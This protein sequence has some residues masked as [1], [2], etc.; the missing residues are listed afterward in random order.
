[1]EKL[2]AAG[3]DKMS[4][5]IE[6]GAEMHHTP[7]AVAGYTQTELDLRRV[8]VGSTSDDIGCIAVNGPEPEQIN[9]F[10]DPNI[11]NAAMITLWSGKDAV[12]QK[13]AVCET[14]SPSYMADLDLLAQNLRRWRHCSIIGPGNAECW[15]LNRRFDELVEKY[16]SYLDD[17]SAPR[18]KPANVYMML[19]KRGHMHFDNSDAM[20]AAEAQM[21]KTRYVGH[22][23]P[24]SY[25]MRWA[26]NGSALAPHA[27]ARGGFQRPVAECLT[28]SIG[29]LAFESLRGRIARRHSSRQQPM[30]PSRTISASTKR[31]RRKHDTPIDDTDDGDRPPYPKLGPSGARE[32]GAAA[33]APVTMKR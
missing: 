7:R 11:E 23:Q 5:N 26:E 32:L 15:S 16:T 17:R 24:Q 31:K 3:V 2:K 13:G 27:R 12:A 14:P 8:V 20:V 6:A 18:A 9:G 21:T 25:D 22:A 4:W 10:E 1:M 33:R 28:V 30:G 19:G 29:A